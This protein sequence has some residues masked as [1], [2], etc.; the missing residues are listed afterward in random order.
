MQFPY[1]PIPQFPAL[2]SELQLLNKRPPPPPSPVAITTLWPSVAVCVVGRARVLVQFVHV[3]VHVLH[4]VHRHIGRYIY[5]LQYRYINHSFMAILLICRCG[6][7]III[8][9]IHISSPLLPCSTLFPGLL[10]LSVCDRTRS[11][12]SLWH[13]ARAIISAITIMGLV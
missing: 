8:I 2:K 6:N 1:H 4:T 5:K 3:A 12:V 10:R 9:I 7:K 11:V 13:D